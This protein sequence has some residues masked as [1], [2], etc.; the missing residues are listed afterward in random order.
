MPQV[1]SMAAT[2]L[3]PR[4]TA[5]ALELA[6]AMARVATAGATVVA[7]ARKRR[8]RRRRR[9][10]SSTIGTRM[11]LCTTPRRIRTTLAR[12]AT[13][14]TRR[15]CALAESPPSPRTQGLVSKLRDGS[16]RVAQRV[17]PA[18]ATAGSVAGAALAAVGAGFV[19]IA[20]F[21]TVSGTA[22]GLSGPD[23]PDSEEEDDHAA[24]L[25]HDYTAFLSRSDPEVRSADGAR[26]LLATGAATSRAGSAPL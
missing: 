4:A 21:G 12:A 5:M 10:W 9:R 25:H 3:S 6:P 13:P 20:T 24:Q 17:G 22:L 11:L 18:L 26:A 15:H 16:S 7:P 14:P 2:T 19:E 23:S 8:A 1:L